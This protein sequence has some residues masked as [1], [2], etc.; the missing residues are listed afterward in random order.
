M[1]LCHPHCVDCNL[2][3]V[4]AMSS[5]V[6]HLRVKDWV[7]VGCLEFVEDKVSVTDAVRRSLEAF[8]LVLQRQG[9]LQKYTQTQVDERLFELKLAIPGDVPDPLDLDLTQFDS[10]LKEARDATADTAPAEIGA[11]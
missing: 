3:L 5:R 10:I 9:K 8:I 4:A 6:L 11:E 1:A 2:E 7:L